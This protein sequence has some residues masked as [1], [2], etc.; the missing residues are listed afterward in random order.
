M[1]IM[2]NEPTAGDYPLSKRDTIMGI[3]NYVS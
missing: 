1:K 3:L 2:I